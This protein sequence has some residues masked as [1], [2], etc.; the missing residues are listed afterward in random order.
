MIDK[1]LMGQ[2]VYMDPQFADG[3]VGCWLFNDS[4]AVAGLTYDTS[5]YGNHGTLVADT[6]SVPGKFG[7]ALNFDG[8]GDYVS[9]ADHSS[10]DI[11]SAITI[12]AIVQLWTLPSLPNGA[13]TILQ[14]GYH[15]AEGNEPYAFRVDNN[16][17][18]GGH[19]LHFGTFSGSETQV[20]WVHSYGVDEWHHVIA[21]FTGTHY[22]L[23]S[24]GAEVASLTNSTQLSTSAYPLTIGASYIE[25][26]S[27]EFDG[28]IDHVMLWN[29]VL[30]AEEILK[31]YQDPFWGFRKNEAGIYAL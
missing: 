5:G 31:L 12:S 1:P 6:H 18:E 17:A 3:L 4:P 7:N 8:A 14:K 20:E 26:Y 11:T 29:R 10:L 2:D 24:D 23:F 30:A 15:S 21:S 9:V 16:A 13:Y 25:G 28:A 22:K 27:R 19:H